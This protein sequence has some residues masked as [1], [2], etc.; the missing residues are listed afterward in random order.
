[1]V[2]KITGCDPKVYEEVCKTYGATGAPDRSGT[3]IYAMGATQHTYG[4]Q[5][6]RAYSIL[7]LLLGNMGVAGGG[8]NALRGESNVQGSTDFAMLFNILPGYNPAPTASCKTLK[9]YNEK[10]TPTS[11]DPKSLNWQANRPKYI[12]SMLKAKYGNYATKE[13]DFAYHLVPKMD[14]GK[15]YSF[16]TLFETMYKGGIEGVFLWGMNPAVSGPNS[17]M[18]RKALSKLKWMVAI[19][20]W[21]TETAAFWEGPEANPKEIQTEVFLLP[22]AASFEKEGSVSNSGRMV[23]WRYRAVSPPGEA[24]SDLDIATELYYELVDLYA[25]PGGV[26]PEAVTKLTW[27]YGLKSPGG[28]FF[29]DADPVFVAKEFNGYAL[30][31]ITDPKTNQVLVKAGEQ[32]PSF[33]LLKDDGSTVC[34]CWIYC[35]A[36]TEKGNMMARRSLRDPTGIGLFPDWSW[37]WPVNRRILYNRASVD[38]EGKPFNTKKP[39]VWWDGAKWQGDVPDGPQPPGAIYPFIMNRGGVARLYG[40]GL[41]DGPLPEHYEPLECTI[42][43][44]LSSRQINPTIKRWDIEGS[45]M[46]IA[47]T[48]GSQYCSS[49]PFIAT[50]YR[51]TEHWQTGQM[52]RWLPWL[53]EAMPEAFIEVSEELGEEKGIRSGDLVN[54][55]SVRAPDGIKVRAIVTKRFKPYKLDGQTMHVVGLPWHWG[56]KG[57]ATGPII[58]EL[59]PSIGDANT[60]IPEYKAFLVNIK[61]ARV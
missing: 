28:R 49:Y 30:A 58:N 60:M 47:A 35:G 54:V 42:K 55:S 5:N 8:I 14:D 17:R 7:Q 20:L 48:F 36:Y 9:D 16:M 51:V 19:D 33:A 44:L 52:T 40:L 37:V 10:F 2:A 56:Y 46:S 39:V 57:L 6:V 22:A 31:E 29:K 3:I 24:R 11:A 61:K 4:S 27:N 45:E 50:T 13:N 59:T 38:W 23:Q 18:M 43:N 25:K 34:G 12:V 32:I 41:V 21:E 26:L 53:V 15:N 1:M